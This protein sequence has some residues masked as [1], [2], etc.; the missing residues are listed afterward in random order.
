MK[1]WHLYWQV[2]YSYSV[3]Q[4]VIFA[5]PGGKGNK[6]NLDDDSEATE[7]LINKVCAKFMK[8]FDA[9]MDEKFSNINKKLDEMSN[10][11][12]ALSLSVADNS[13]TL[14][15][16]DEKL[17]SLEQ[18]TKNNS[19]RVL[20]I[21]EQDNENIPETI[22]QFINNKLKV[23]CELRDIDYVYRIG[24]FN[25]NGDKPR[26]V[27]VKFVQNIKK[28]EI[29]YVRK[30]LKNSDFIVFEDLTARRY[31]LLLAVKKKYG[32]KKAWSS[33]GKIY[34]WDD[35]LKKKMQVN[36]LNDLK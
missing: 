22:I 18:L 24:K 27:L 29:L 11:M 23:T 7:K 9:K 6:A 8:Q 36:S 19:L 21:P 15:R 17:D 35:G 16:M 28:N 25:E 32:N 14:C 30:L 5:M 12:N 31:E 4:V 2:I 26:P 34:F 1:V 33:A 20:G 13:E 10:S 3:D